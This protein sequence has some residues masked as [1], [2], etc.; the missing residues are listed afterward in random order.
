MERERERERERE[1]D[2]ISRC[3]GGFRVGHPEEC[4]TVCER[5][6]VCVLCLAGQTAETQ[7]IKQ[8]FDTR[9]PVSC[10]RSFN[11]VV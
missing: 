2:R 1:K 4:L 3:Q 10:Q 6:R 9:H 7:I 11:V 8:S 5:G